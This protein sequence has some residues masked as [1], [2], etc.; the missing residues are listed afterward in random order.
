MG[1]LG[2]CSPLFSRRGDMGE[3]AIVAI[4]TST[5]LAEEATCLRR[6]GCRWALTILPPCSAGVTSA[7]V[8]R[9]KS[10]GLRLLPVHFVLKAIHLV[11]FE[12]FAARSQ[13]LSVVQTSDGFAEMAVMQT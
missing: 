11:S 4:S 12:R 2:W 13:V 8:Q 10:V 7:E 5:C 6:G 1:T 3:L 9:V